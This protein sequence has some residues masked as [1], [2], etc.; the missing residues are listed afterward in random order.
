MFL[1]I[2]KKLR[3]L[4]N[5]NITL[6]EHEKKTIY[7]FIN[8]KCNFQSIKITIKREIEKHIMKREQIQQ[9][10]GYGES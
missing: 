2:D 3:N 7:Y 8:R 10:H 6:E 1:T 5:K 4:V 9:N